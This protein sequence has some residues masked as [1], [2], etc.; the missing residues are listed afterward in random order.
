MEDIHTCLKAGERISNERKAV[1]VVVGAGSWETEESETS[2][3]V[4]LA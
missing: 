3:C 1:R 4:R 2:H